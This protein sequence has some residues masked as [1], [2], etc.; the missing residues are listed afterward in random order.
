[1]I[2][3]GFKSLSLVS[4]FKPLG[5]YVLQTGLGAGRLIFNR[6]FQNVSRVNDCLILLSNLFHSNI[7][8][9]KKEY[10]KASVLL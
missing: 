4:N 5:L 6:E 1:M 10:L 7:V 8:D 3:I 2:Y 9:G